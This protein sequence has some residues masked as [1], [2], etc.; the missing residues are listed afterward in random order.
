MNVPTFAYHFFRQ[1]Q[2]IP[3]SVSMDESL[4]N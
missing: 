3:K 2:D 1:N 4:A